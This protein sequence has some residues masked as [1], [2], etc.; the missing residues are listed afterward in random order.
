[1]GLWNIDYDFTEDSE[2]VYA[3]SYDLRIV[4]ALMKQGYTYSQ[5]IQIAATEMEGASEKGG[6]VFSRQTYCNILNEEG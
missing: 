4:D 3:P 1:M 5:A 6:V 2:E